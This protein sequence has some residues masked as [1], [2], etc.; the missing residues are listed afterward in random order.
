MWYVE[1][2]RGLQ[3]SAKGL[4]GSDQS[5]YVSRGLQGSVEVWWCLQESAEVCRSLIGSAG[6]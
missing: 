5:A 6:A 1:I 3:R 2:C 4:Q